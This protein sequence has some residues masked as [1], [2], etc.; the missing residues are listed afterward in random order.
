MSYPDVFVK[1]AERYPGYNMILTSRLWKV[2]LQNNYFKLL[3][4]LFWKYYKKKHHYSAKL[5]SEI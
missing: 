4:V 3:G 5:G 1:I 2:V